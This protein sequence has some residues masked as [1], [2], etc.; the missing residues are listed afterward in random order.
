MGVT[1]RALEG[2]VLDDEPEMER[3]Q[4]QSS[5]EGPRP[6]ILK[7]EGDTDIDLLL[8]EEAVLSAGERPIQRDAH[9]IDAR[10]DV[11]RGGRE[12]GRRGIHGVR[13]GSEVELEANLPRA[14]LVLDRKS[15]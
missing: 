3:R 12:D 8:G 1:L 14:G 9:R 10:A 7:L 11:R 2:L 5:V 13:I 6:G 4:L 15:V